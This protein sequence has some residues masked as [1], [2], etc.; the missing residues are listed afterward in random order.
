MV[1]LSRTLSR[2]VAEATIR[3]TAPIPALLRAAL[4]GT[5][6]YLPVRVLRNDDFHPSLQ[7]SDEWIRTRTGISER[8]IA[9][10]DESSFTLGLEA[11]R[12]ALRCSGLSARDI[13][14]IVFATVTPQTMVPSNACRL[15]AALGCRSI[16]AFDVAAACTGFV[17]ALA[18]ANQ[19]IATGAC[20]HVLVVGAEVLS[21]TLDY[22]D[23]NTC[24]LFGD[25]AGAAIFSSSPADGPGVHWVELFS[26]GLR[27][28]LIHMPSHVTHR[29]LPSTTEAIVAPPRPFVRL[30]GREVFKFAVRALVGLVHEALAAVPLPATGRLFLVPH[31]VN[32]RIIDAALPELPIPPD[33]VILNLDRYGNTSAASIPIALDEA[34]RK[35]T[36]ESGDHVIL[37]AFGG[38]LTWGGALLTL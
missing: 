29:G 28:D 8:H 16:A 32:Q 31:Q 5:G 24:I 33:R 15:Q 13:D 4:N 34:L 27:G 20:Q 10:P 23:R 3:P 12:E 6:K 25:G 36:F 1:M 26:D 7:T 18:I 2:P 11:S 37:A 17:Q 22:S 19:F 14:L 38:G 35:H 30:N 9:G 21:R